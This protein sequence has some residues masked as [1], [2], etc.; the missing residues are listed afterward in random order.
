MRREDRLPVLIGRDALGVLGALAVNAKALL[1]NLGVG[2]AYERA[3]G[4]FSQLDFEPF[5]YDFTR[6]TPN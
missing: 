6:Y 1:R 5:S 2:P 4:D 3:K